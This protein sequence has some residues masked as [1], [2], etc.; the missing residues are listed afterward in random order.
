MSAST[1]TLELVRRQVDAEHDFAVVVPTGTIWC[2]DEELGELKGYCFGGDSWLVH[3]CAHGLKNPDNGLPVKR[4]HLVYCSTPLPRATRMC[5]GD[6]R[7][8]N[9]GN[10]ATIHESPAIPEGFHRAFV[11]DIQDEVRKKKNELRTRSPKWGRCENDDMSDAESADDETY[12]TYRNDLEYDETD[13]CY[14]LCENYPTVTCTRCRKRIS[15]QSYTGPHTRTRG[16]LLRYSPFRSPSRPWMAKAKAKAAAK[17]A[18]KAAG[19]KAA[20]KA[21]AAAPPKPPPP[22]PKPPGLKA[23]PPKGPP[24]APAVAPLAKVLP[25]PAPAPPPGDAGDEEKDDRSMPPKTIAAKDLPE[26]YEKGKQRRAELEQ[27]VSPLEEQAR[28]LKPAHHPR[29][30]KF[31][32]ELI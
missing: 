32:E 6:G 17:A 30:T 14:H 7:H 29:A 26:E 16:C 21:K 1:T 19:A 9:H 20:L 27:G 31:F 2:S 11:L 24:L 12:A 22:V 3:M 10:R 25:K 4:P 28:G 5:P 13:E 15:G 8:P 18:L 23:P